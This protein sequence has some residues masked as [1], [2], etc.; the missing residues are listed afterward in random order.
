MHWLVKGVIG[1]AEGLA[2]GVARRKRLSAGA[3]RPEPPPPG[4]L[5]P[6]ACG[7]TKRFP[8]VV[9]NDGVDFEAAVGEVHALLGENGAGK[10]DALEHPHRALPAGRGR[11]RA[12]RRGRCASRRR[13]TRSPP[14]SAWCTSTSAS[15][16]RSPSPRTSSSATTAASAGRSSSARGAI[17]R[18]VAELGRALRARRRAA[19][20][21]LAALGRR[22][23]ARRD[24]E[25][26][27]PRRA[28]PDPRRADRRA[29]AAGGRGALRDAAHD[30]GGRAGRSSSSRT[31]CTR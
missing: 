13:A 17:E 24:P 20:A 23:A 30:G 14:G 11:D 4:R 22:A 6:S 2:R 12:V 19:R 15:C 9:A 25:G 3:R 26:A 18:R 7:I 16:R 29:H 5:W 21:D 28:D 10:S 1:S 27:L 8:G 31:S